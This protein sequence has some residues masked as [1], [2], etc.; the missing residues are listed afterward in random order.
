MDDNRNELVK[1]LKDL[2]ALLTEPNFHPGL[3]GWQIMYAN[4]AKALVAF[5]QD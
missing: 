2:L 1:L 5:Y 3:M 4:K